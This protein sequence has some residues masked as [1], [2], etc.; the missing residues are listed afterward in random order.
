MRLV[1]FTSIFFLLSACRLSN[2][3]KQE[4]EDTRTA[5]SLINET[6]PYLLQHAY[7]PVHWLPWGD[8][9][10]ARAKKE[11]KLIII[12][13]GY[14]SCHWCH[15]MEH[16]SFENK[17][18]AALM[19]EHFINIKVDRE[20]RPD[21]DQV[22]MTAVQLMT[23]SGG[24][25]LNCIT[26]PDG[27]P[28][29]GGTYFPKA[30]WMNILN[31]LQQEYKSNPE[32]MNEYATKLASGIQQVELID[33]VEPEGKVS[34]TD[35][36]AKIREIT[37]S[38]D[39]KRGG[40]NRA[41]KFPIPNNLEFF[42]HYYQQTRDSAFLTHV[43]RT[44]DE[45]ANGGLYDQVG[46][47]FARY[48]VDADWKI[49]HFEK[50]LYD[51]AQLI[52]VYSHAY[53]LTGNSRYKKVVEETFEFLNREM[54]GDAELYYSA[55]DADSEGEEGKF[56]V[57]KESELKTVLGSDYEKAVTH[58]RIGNETLWEHGNHHLVR[59]PDSKLSDEEADAL[60]H[61]LLKG[62]SSRVR[63]GLDDKCLTS[64]NGL[65]ISGLVDAYKAFGDSRYLQQAEKSMALLL[66]HQLQDGR[67]KHS[68]KEGRS[69]INGFLEDYAFVCTALIDL[70]EATLEVRYLHQAK[71][72][73]DHAISKFTD[74]SSGML[75]FTSS[76]DPALIA[77]KTEVGD[78]VIPASNSAMAIVIE[79]L[80]RYQEDTAYV[81]LAQTM[82]QN[83]EPHL[84][85]YPSG[86]TNWARL[87]MI[88]HYPYY[89]VAVCG[90]EAQTTANR[91]TRHY[92]PNALILGTVSEEHLPLLRN[93][94]VADQTTIYVCVNKSCKAP[95]TDYKEALEELLP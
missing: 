67:L 33:R 89:E 61:A 24:W 57:W 84:L 68:F 26:L 59:D 56:Y 29:Y 47:G 64:W 55:L 74:P 16:E 93:K 69:T 44:L 14:S 83:M 2:N 77:R 40:F 31:Q 90:L 32:R 91:I 86:Y 27:R 79:K 10:L 11:N 30:S 35:F 66:K 12:S 92:L 75:F 49:P 45:M 38:F 42:L 43:I 8:E 20:E 1:A 87:W 15:V 48:S 76:D 81:S 36:E 80:G 17:E 53:Q 13:I 95:T 7:N 73:T 58:F 18:V 5:N 71:A 46:G 85:R 23:G 51:N 82:I 39:E 88:H 3:P 22:Y 63:P 60:R 41:P 37:A 72:I 78:N 54:K 21:I 65:L 9:A 28:V 70:Y 52:S 62:R 94:V 6:S 19:N 4:M 34:T 50:M 25:P